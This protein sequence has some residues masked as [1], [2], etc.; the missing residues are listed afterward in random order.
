MIPE[1]ETPSHTNR[2]LITWDLVVNGSLVF[3]IL[4]V[5][6]IDYVK[7]QFYCRD[8]SFVLRGLITE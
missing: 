3:D 5:V 8:F 4:I 1:P 2:L 6:D 7:I